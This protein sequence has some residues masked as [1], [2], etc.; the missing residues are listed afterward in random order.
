MLLLSVEIARELEAETLAKLNYNQQGSIDMEMEEDEAMKTE[1]VEEE[2]TT[3]GSISSSQPV[4]K[5]QN[6]RAS[7]QGKKY[8]PA[9]TCQKIEL[10]EVTTN[11]SFFAFFHVPS[12]LDGV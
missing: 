9:V 10:I 7:H 4:L 8:L 5:P 1:G 6:Q 2:M 3:N 12:C 11:S